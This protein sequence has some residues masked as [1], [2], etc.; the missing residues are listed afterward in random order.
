MTNWEALNADVGDRVV[1]RED[2]EAWTGTVSLAVEPDS[3]RQVEFLTVHRDSDGR[4]YQ[5][6]RE[7]VDAAR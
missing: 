1:V 7:D 2:G 3:E 5:V 4:V 6:R